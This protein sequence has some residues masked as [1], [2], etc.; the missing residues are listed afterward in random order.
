MSGLCPGYSEA[1]DGEMRDGRGEEEARIGK[2][3][4]GLVGRALPLRGEIG[5]QAFARLL[6]C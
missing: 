6:A 4:S 1:A 5:R 2:R 3:Q